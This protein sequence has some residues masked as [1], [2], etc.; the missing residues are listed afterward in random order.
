MSLCIVSMIG[1]E[2]EKY[3]WELSAWLFSLAYLKKY[4]IMVSTKVELKTK[5]SQS[6]V[7]VQVAFLKTPH[8]SC[9][10]N[11]TS[12]SNVYS[13]T[14]PNLSLGKLIKFHV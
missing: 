11:T 4:A 9:S 6:S 10:C 7:Q 12:E 3:M 8:A 14:R 1:C 5:I 2:P 13:D